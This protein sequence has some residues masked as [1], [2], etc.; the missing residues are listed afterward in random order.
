MNEA[1]IISGDTDQI[2][3]RIESDFNA[4]PDVY[5]Y[6]A[7]IEQQ[8]RSVMLDIDID[9]GGGFESGY[10]LTRLTSNLKTFNQFKFSIH[11]QDFID[12]VGKFF[13]MEDV[14]LGYVE[15]DKKIV[16]KTNDADRA[17]SIL[18][19]SSMREVIQSLE[20]FTFHIGHHSS[21]NTEVEAA[22][23]E[24]RINEGILEIS[25]LRAIYEAFVSV[26]RKIEPSTGSI[27][28]N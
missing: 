21:H 16:V 13:G 23:L 3:K 27:I 28:N 17:K 20:D 10:A 1:K 14:E 22:F 26:L 24:L 19:D 15:F 6:S 9:L 4:D 18:Y 5:E 25:R 12:T 8:D 2:W 11:P 7:V